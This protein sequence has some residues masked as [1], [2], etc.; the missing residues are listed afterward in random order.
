[1]RFKQ[2]VFALGV[3][4]G[5]PITLDGD[6]Q[7]EQKMTQATS[8]LLH[9]ELADWITHAQEKHPALL[10]ARSQLVAAQEKVRATQAEGLP[11]LDLIAN[12]YQNGRPNQSIS[13]TGTEESLIGLTLTIPLFEGFARTYKVRNVQAQ[14]DQKRAD[15]EDLEHQVM[16][17]VAKAHAEA[18]AA[19]DNLEASST[20]IRSAESSL[21]SVQRKFEGGAAD[22]V[23]MLNS[24]AA[25][26]DAQQERIRCQA[27]WRSAQLRLLA[28]TGILGRHML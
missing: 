9:Q 4:A 13:S 21:S 22:I 7:A 14:V 23:E 6:F 18:T 10:A 11:T 1:M 12:R 16:L 8:E 3:P 20:L 27:E 25:F 26:S 28:S 2:L 15:I 5:T 19:L 17:E 24:Q